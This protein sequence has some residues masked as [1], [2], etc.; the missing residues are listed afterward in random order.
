[1]PG[2]NHEKRELY[3][4][5][6]PPEALSCHFRIPNLAFYVH[7]HPSKLSAASSL[8]PHG[9]AIGVLLSAPGS[10]HPCK[11]SSWVGIEVLS[12]DTQTIP[13]NPASRAL[14]NDLFLGE[15][16]TVPLTPALVSQLHSILH[17]HRIPATVKKKKTYW[18]ASLLSVGVALVVGTF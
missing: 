11:G 10:V 14:P 15:I 5:W 12:P 9:S 2:E 3:Y 7:S 8:L 16:L 6:G 13:Y 1:M 4:S 18:K 17:Y